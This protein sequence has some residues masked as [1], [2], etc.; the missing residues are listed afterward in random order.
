MECFRI[1]LIG[2][3]IAAIDIQSRYLFISGH[4]PLHL[5]IFNDHY[6]KGVG[7]C[8]EGLSNQLPQ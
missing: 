7:I 2:E 8:L 4:H 3:Y 5:V 1:N 6:L